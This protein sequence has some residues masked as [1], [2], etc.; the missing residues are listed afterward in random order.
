MDT[1]R[2][3]GR[4]N[5]ASHGHRNQG[6]IKK[7][8]AETIRAEKTEGKQMKTEDKQRERHRQSDKKLTEKR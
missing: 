8:E 7:Q 1:A 4:E 5:A 2:P 3:E 6:R